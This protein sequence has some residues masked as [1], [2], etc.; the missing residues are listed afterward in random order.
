MN[1]ILPTLIISTL[2]IISCKNW[3]C[4]LDKIENEENII[5]YAA[6]DFEIDGTLYFVAGPSLS[7]IDTTEE[8]HNTQWDF[9]KLEGKEFSKL[10]EVSYLYDNR[11]W[12]FKWSPKGNY[13]SFFNDMGGEVP[14]T[15]DIGILDPSSLEEIYLTDNL[16]DA[17]PGD[18]C[19]FNW[20]QSEEYI[21]FTA[22]E[23]G[24][25]EYEKT[26]N[27]DIYR[28]K[29]DGTGLENLTNSTYFEMVATPSPDGSKLAYIVDNKNNTPE[30]VQGYYIM[31]LNTGV[32]Q[33][34]MNVPYNIYAYGDY[35]KWHPSS[36]HL[37]F[38]SERTHPNRVLFYNIK[39][40]EH[41]FLPS[42]SDDWRVYDCT[43]INKTN[44]AVLW[45]HSFTQDYVSNENDNFYLF[46]LVSK[47]MEDISEYFNP[48]DETYSDR[49]WGESVSSPDGRFIAYRVAKHLV[50]YDDEI[51]DY[52]ITDWSGIY[53][54]TDIF[55][56]NLES[57]ELIKLTNGNNTWEG[58]LRWVE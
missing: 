32:S 28:I 16:G 12:G 6:I 53:L 14:N 47:S 52:P 26:A 58:Y 15:D 21:Y 48:Y 56:L 55:L 10:N 50:Y 33:M 36:D 51:S 57:Y 54:T 37:F 11:Y 40:D 19:V 46:D 13:F 22:L 29:L 1:K 3:M 41:Y 24:V 42:F 25:S 44:K 34:I 39:N 7:D 31:D 38:I 20:S 27:S 49:Y 23:Y 8:Y 4:D 18:Q 5:Q 43:F 17:N 45:I 35:I 9:W 2:L 30:S